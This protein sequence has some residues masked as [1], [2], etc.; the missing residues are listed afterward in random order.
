MN[1]KTFW[2]AL[3]VGVGILIGGCGQKQESVMPI[4]G[5]A[6]FETLVKAHPKY[7]EYFKLETE[8]KNMTEEYTQ[9][10]NQLIKVYS[11]KTQIDNVLEN[12]VHVESAQKELESRIKSKEDELNEKLKKLYNDILSKHRD[13]IIINDN[14][15]EDSIRLAN[16]QMKI[17]VVGISEKER[18]QAKREIQDLLNKRFSFDEDMSDWT[19]FEKSQFLKAKEDASNELENFAKNSANEIK[20]KL[21]KRQLKKINSNDSSYPE[22]ESWDKNWQKKLEIKQEQMAKIKSEIMKDIRKDAEKVALE[23]NLYMI[24]S[25]HTINVDAVDVT[26]DIVNKI[27]QEE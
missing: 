2:A 18:E 20:E 24:F 12:K 10:R 21:S 27:I 19:E 5:V 4:Y 13:K 15:P 16:L 11:T 9:E 22:L 8:Y 6:D 26:G 23:K 1:K 14:L 3:L 25:D 17:L 7:S